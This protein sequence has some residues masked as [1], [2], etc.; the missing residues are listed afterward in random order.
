MPIVPADL[1]GAAEDRLVRL[2]ANRVQM[3][4]YIKLKLSE[5][6]LHGVADGAMD[7]RDLDAEIKGIEFMR[8]LRNVPDA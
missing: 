6:D 4:E 5:D 1:P 3:I 8:G 2:K 7:V